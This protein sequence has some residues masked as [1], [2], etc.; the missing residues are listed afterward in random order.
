MVCECVC[1]CV[2]VCVVC[3]M[4]RIALSAHT[5]H[6]THTT[7]HDGKVRYSTQSRVSSSY[8]PV[9]CPYLLLEKGPQL[10]VAEHAVEDTVADEVISTI[11]LAASRQF[12]LGLLLAR[13]AT[14]ASAVTR[15]LLSDS[16]DAPREPRAYARDLRTFASRPASAF[17]P[18]LRLVHRRG[19]AACVV[20]AVGELQQ[21]LRLLH[22]VATA[23][24][25]ARTAAHHRAVLKVRAL[26]IGELVGFQLA[27]QE[28]HMRTPATITAAMITKMTRL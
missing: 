21:R 28:Q 20:H 8:G 2:C 15:S 24:A 3:W 12:A 27:G 19:F 13:S 26:D 10:A 17:R 4:S 22:G 6:Y 9:T 7:R 18:P 25:V 1:V 5:T 23:V 14:V 11:P 16:L